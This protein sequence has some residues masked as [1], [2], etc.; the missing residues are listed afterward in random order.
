MGAR[1]TC[2]LYS[3]QCA[4]CEQKAAFH[5]HS[6]PCTCWL[7]AC[8]VTRSK[9]AQGCP[10]CQSTRVKERM[11]I[12]GADCRYRPDL[13]DA[14]V[15][16]AI[17]FLGSINILRDSFEAGTNKEGGELG[18]IWFCVGE[19]I[20]NTLRTFPSWFNAEILAVEQMTNQL[21]LF[22]VLLLLTLIWTNNWKWLF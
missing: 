15:V 17:T 3:K 7:L 8:E 12:V 13:G 22:L 20:S 6:V 5:W 11:L 16:K 18:V 19:L 1:Q 9:R 21:L 10:H 14:S 2:L 4:R